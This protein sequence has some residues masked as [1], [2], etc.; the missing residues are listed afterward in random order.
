M[1]LPRSAGTFLISR[2]AIS[3]SD[4]AVSTSNTISPASSSRIVSR[5][6]RV[7]PMLG[8]L[9]FFD[10]D[11]VLAVVLLEPHGD[12]LAARGRQVLADVVR[13]DRQLAVTAVDQARELDGGRTS[14]VDDRVERRAD[15]PS[16]EEDVVHEDHRLVL[17][18]EWDV[19]AADHRRPAHAQVVAVERDV[20]RPDR[21][22][23]AVDLRDLRGKAMREAHAARPQPDEREVLGA[24]VLLQD[25][26]GDAGEGPVERGLVEDLRFLPVA[27]WGAAHLLSLRAS[28]GSLK[29]KH[30]IDSRHSTWR[31]PPVSTS[32]IAPFKMLPSGNR[33]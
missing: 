31:A 15:R 17:D 3:W 9:G 20:E 6:F 14:E 21:K 10:D 5:S 30:L 28:P 11:A 19:G 22:C 8:L 29:G 32:R 24:A 16:R 7:Q 33:R 1:V 18:R 25:L 26:V 2:V 13:P 27:W 4:A 12:G 23:R